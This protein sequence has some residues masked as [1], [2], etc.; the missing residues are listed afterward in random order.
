MLR[1][2]LSRSSRSAVMSRAVLFVATG[3][4]A[5]LSPVGPGTVGSLLGVPLALLLWGITVRSLW[6]S[7]LVGGAVLAGGV[8]VAGEAERLVGEKDSPR[9]VIDEIIGF[10]IATYMLEPSAGS[11]GSAFFLF[12]LFDIVKPFPARHADRRVRGGVGIVLD[13]VVAGA[14]ANAAA[15]VFLWLSAR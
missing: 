9:I 10:A 15:R 5:G 11:Y 1:S 4:Y 7:A 13:D 6:A 12:R 3:A 14:Y 8:W 2:P